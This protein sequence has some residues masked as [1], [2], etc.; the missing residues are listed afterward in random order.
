MSGRSVADVRADLERDDLWLLRYLNTSV[1][2]ASRTVEVSA[3]RLLSRLAT[4]RDGLGC[5]LALDGLVPPA[6]TGASRPSRG[7]SSLL[8]AAG[9]VPDGLSAAVG[10]A[11]AEPDP[12]RPRR[13]QAIVVVHRGRIVAERYAD[14]LTADTPLAGWS[15]TKSVTG[16]LSGIL[17][18]EG[19]LALDVRLPMPEWQSMGDPR[20]AI[21]L[22]H[23]LRMSSGLRFDEGMASPRSDIMQMLFATGDASGFAVRQPLAGAPGS[24]WQYSSGTTNVIAR[25]IR[26]ALQDDDA[27][28]RFPRE[29]LFDRIGMTSATMETDATGTFVGSSFM[30]AT[31]R[32]WARFGLLYLTDGVVGDERVLPDG[33][34]KY[35]TTPAPSDPAGRY[36]AHVWLDVPDEYAGSGCRLPAGTFHAA[37]HEAQF[38]TI[39]P[40]QDVV[41]VRLGRTRWP[42]VWDQC[43]FVHEVLASLATH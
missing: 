19:R 42:D 18:G 29:A 1:D 10:R 16:A 4:F 20:A 9:P 41:I 31:A 26:H 12:Q 17:V 40:S 28:W 14:G 27:Y 43:A 33:W 11:F 30:Y 3:L 39:V 23:L 36:G 7:L 25:I 34:V 6:P 15:M 37:G 5:A 13:T 35:T 24:T 22:D 32:D 38:V 8:P 21:T 2:P